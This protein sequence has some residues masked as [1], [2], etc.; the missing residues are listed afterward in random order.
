MSAYNEYNILPSE[1]TY[2]GMC[3]NS[4][5]G[6]PYNNGG[7]GNGNGNSYGT[8]G[9]QGNG[10]GNLN[11]HSVP[12]TDGIWILLLLSLIYIYSLKKVKFGLTL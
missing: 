1:A 12:I 10:K 5:N 4:D 2:R 11:P 9:N 7:N 6:I 3:G 8:D